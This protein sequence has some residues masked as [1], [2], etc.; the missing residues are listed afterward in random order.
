MLGELLF[1]GYHKAEYEVAPDSKLRVAR[2]AF[3]KQIWFVTIYS[4][5]VCA[6]EFAYL[7]TKTAL[8]PVGEVYRDYPL[9][10]ETAV[11]LLATVLTFIAIKSK[12]AS[13]F[14]S[15]IYLAASGYMLFKRSGFFLLLCIVGAVVYL[16][17]IFVHIHMGY[18]KARGDIDDL[19]EIIEVMG[20]TTNNRE[21]LKKVYR[22]YG[23]GGE[24]PVNN[25][26]SFEKIL[27]ADVDLLKEN[28]I[29]TLMNEST[30]KSDW[31]SS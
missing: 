7:F 16:K 1:F 4:F 6:F 30:D 28:D 21:E 3:A 29:E 10:I 22:R 15:A 18:I 20:G 17:M 14:L 11:M 5:V 8:R 25:Q 24:N 19:D 26:K 12:F 9:M 27:D 2:N 13:G 23:F 31:L